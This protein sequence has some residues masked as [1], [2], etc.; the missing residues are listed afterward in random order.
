MMNDDATPPEVP[1]RLNEDWRYG[2]PQQ[3]AAELAARINGRGTGELTTD[4]PAECVRRSLPEGA[5]ACP[6]SIG[7]DYFLRRA[8]QSGG[9]VLHIVLPR[10]EWGTA[11]VPLRIRCHTGSFYAPQLCVELLPGS[12]AHI[13][14]EH[15]H[16][17]NSA[18]V[19]LR[20][21][22]VHPDAELR[23]ELRETGDDASRTMN[24]SR[25]QC[26]ENARARQLTTCSGL[27]WARE[28][29][30]GEL[31]GA[32]AELLLLSANRPEGGQW[33]DQRCRQLHHAAGARSR[34]LY[35]NV[36]RDA[37]TCIFGGNIR[38][39]PGAHESDAYLSNLNL[40]L[41]AEAAVH[42]LPQL[43]IMADRVR[44]SHGSA[45]APIDPEQ[46]FYLRS[47][48]IGEADAQAIL[49][50]AFLHEVYLLFNQP[51][52]TQP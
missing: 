44:C 12:R 23:L 8:L 2:R 14:E 27:A 17:R 40:M 41:S 43:E 51:R 26:R 28:E 18:L 32:E 25:I 6:P 42:S 5:D 47:R 35:K 20:S 3:F 22:T 4:A 36:L 13:L 15:T 49:A 38:V 7:S 52:S 30:T 10:G 37:A 16:D 9:D 24:I 1:N 46:L 11:E 34:A 29:T 50:D 48:G 19:C 39:E 33:L 31:C 21:Y 45:S